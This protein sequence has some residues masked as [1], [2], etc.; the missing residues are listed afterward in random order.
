MFSFSSLRRTSIAG[1]ACRI[2]FI[3]LSLVPF[4]VKLVRHKYGFN[5]GFLAC[6]NHISRML[7]PISNSCARFT[8]FL[9]TVL[10]I[11]WLASCEQKALLA[12]LQHDLCRTACDIFVYEMSRRR[13]Y[14]GC[15]MRRWGMEKKWHAYVRY[16]IGRRT[17]D[18]QQLLPGYHAN[19][20][21]FLLI[22]SYNASC[23]P[24]CRRLHSPKCVGCIKKKNSTL[25]AKIFIQVEKDDF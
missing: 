14:V 19:V 5:S 18:E 20:W 13:V 10:C 3:I 6:I 12:S 9:S 8:V 22:E 21:L 15:Y 24:R 17:C 16:V 4:H 25:Y 2:Y 7:E 11:S 23:E 1:D